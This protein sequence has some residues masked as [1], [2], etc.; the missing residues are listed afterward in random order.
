MKS[1]N[2][3]EWDCDFGPLRALD[4]QWQLWWAWH[5]VKVRVVTRTVRFENEPGR[6]HAELVHYEWRWL[7]TVARQRCLGLDGIDG[8]VTWAWRYASSHKAVTQ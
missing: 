8:A 7:T 3:E 4:S 6:P 5:P 2:E 1:R